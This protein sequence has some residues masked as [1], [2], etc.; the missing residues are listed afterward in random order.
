MIFNVC[1]ASTTL[2]H[3]SCLRRRFLLVLCRFFVC[4]ADE[5]VFRIR[6]NACN[7]VLRLFWIKN[8]NKC[9][10][11]FWSTKLDAKNEHLQRLFFAWLFFWREFKQRREVFSYW[12]EI[13]STT[14]QE[15][16]VCAHN[17]YTCQV[18]TS[19]AL[20]IY[21]LSGIQCI[22]LFFHMF[23]F[24]FL[25]SYTQHDFMQRILLHKFYFML[26]KPYP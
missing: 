13:A 12:S 25:S 10:L 20:G 17:L 21:L 22:Q 9:G 11:Q 24:V 8:Q 4:Y 2:E 1:K 16:R 5:H 7:F 19:R 3:I 23:C 26:T 18:N 14:H 15:A 6:I